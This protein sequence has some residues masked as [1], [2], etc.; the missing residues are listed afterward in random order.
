M[1]KKIKTTC[2][3]LS[4]EETRKIAKQVG[5]TIEQITQWRKDGRCPYCGELGKYINF[6]P[7]CSTHGPYAT[8]DPRS[9]KPATFN[10][11][12]PPYDD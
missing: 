10:G 11:G 8:T 12:D 7:V 3:E 5:K 6:K 2:E 1:S 4:A 9:K